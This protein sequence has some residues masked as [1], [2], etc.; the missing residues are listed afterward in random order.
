MGQFKVKKR[1]NALQSFMKGLSAGASKSAPKIMEMMMKKSDAEK[2]QKKSFVSNFDKTISSIQNPE[3]KAEANKIK[4]QYLAGEIGLGEFMAFTQGLDASAFTKPEKPL[5]AKQMLEESQA[6][7]ENLEF[8]KD[9]VAPEGDR[10]TKYIGR[11][12]GATEVSEEQWN[13]MVNNLVIEKDRSD[14]RGKIKGE[15]T[16]RELTSDEITTLG[17]DANKKWTTGI[18]GG[19]AE[20]K[21]RLVKSFPAKTKKLLQMAG[22][23]INK[24]DEIIN[25]L[26]STP[27]QKTEAMRKK[28]NWVSKFVEFEV[29]SKEDAERNYGV[30][31]S[32]P[33]KEKIEGF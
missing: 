15:R 3:M 13:Q 21:E 33:E 24:L 10:E 4:Y 5:T 14:L 22:S 12:G 17:L 27:E 31:L 23:E 1:P 20:K 29:L 28:T 26:L 30:V 25:S 11:L 9:E 19:I 32:D 8:T 7:R 16:A 2:D 18:T 6:R